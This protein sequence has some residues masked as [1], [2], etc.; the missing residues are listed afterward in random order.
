MSSRLDERTQALLLPCLLAPEIAD[1]FVRTLSKDLLGQRVPIQTHRENLL[2]KNAIEVH[3]RNYAPLLA[4]HY[5]L[6]PTIVELTGVD[7]LPSFA[8]F[9]LYFEGDI[10]RVHSDRTAA[11]YG[12]SLTLATSDARPWGLSMGTTP[13]SGNIGI[14]DDFGDEAYETYAMTAGDA[15]LYRGISRRHGRVT[16]NPNRWSAHAFMLWVEREGPNRGEA[17]ERLDLGTDPLF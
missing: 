1:A 12:L 4:L 5:G 17:F 10:C 11:E 15:V 8:F 13:V 9:R 3:G 7:L 14:K 16:P 6:T 2:R